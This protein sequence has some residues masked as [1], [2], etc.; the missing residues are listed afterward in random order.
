[1]CEKSV[2]KKLTLCDCF[3]LITFRP[4]SA[5]FLQDLT[6]MQLSHNNHIRL[7][8][9]ARLKFCR[10]MQ[11]CH[12]KYLTFSLYIDDDILSRFLSD[13]LSDKTK[14]PRTGQ[15]TAVFIANCAPHYNKKTTCGRSFA[16]R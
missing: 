4:K 6:I 1:M 5:I 8:E 11:H 2:P 14:P 9:V 16:G 15:R 7:T 12:I 13:I 3:P 10:E